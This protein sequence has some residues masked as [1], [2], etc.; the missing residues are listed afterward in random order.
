MPTQ[1]HTWLVFAVRLLPWYRND[2][3]VLI[4]VKT[5]NASRTMQKLATA[6]FGSGNGDLRRSSMPQM[7]SSI[8]GPMHRNS[9]M[10]KV[11]DGSYV[12]L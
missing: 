9:L 4:L 11:L 6:L 2:S 1:K 3:L 10:V 7:N 5:F 12:Y 8:S